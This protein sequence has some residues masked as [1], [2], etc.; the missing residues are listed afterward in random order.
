MRPVRVRLLQADLHYRSGALVH[1][2]LSGPVSFLSAL[3]LLVEDAHGVRGAGEVRTNIAFV[4]GLAPD[5]VVE[6]AKEA[7]RRLPW[8]EGTEAVLHALDHAP[9]PL[10]VRA[11]IE[12]A[13]RDGEGR[14]AGRGVCEQFGGAIAGRCHPTNHC[15]FHAPAGVMLERARGYLARGFDH[16]KVRLGIN[17]LAADRDFLLR[18][19]DL[20]GPAVHLAIDINAAWPAAAVDRGLQA[21]AE[22]GIA[23]VE[24]PFAADDWAAVAAFAA[25]S[26]VPIMLDETVS[27]PAAVDRLIAA[28]WRQL[29]H[30]K[31]VK[32][33]GI[34]RV[35]ACGRRLKAAGIGVMVGQMNEGGLA[36]AAA[37]HAALALNP[38]HAELYGADDLADDPV[39]G[40]SYQSGTVRLDG[41]A[42]LGV[43]F[44]DGRCRQIAEWT[45]A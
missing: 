43:A 14:A 44:D 34:D 16:L 9:A 12:A 13:L 33:G 11:L 31:I 32:L 3:Y 19:R 6:A 21:L 23:Y 29:A 42:G 38:A 40:I 27:S 30:L 35:V 24:Q 17:D 20:A 28:G 1:T 7:L 18:L 41:T 15:L 22:A 25:G 36:T 45:H 2:A 26:P 37:V 10:P 8:A 39:S 5:V 4:T